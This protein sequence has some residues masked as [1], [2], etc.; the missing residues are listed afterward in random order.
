MSTL[1]RQGDVLFVSVSLPVGLPL[2]SSKQVAVAAGEKAGHRHVLAAAP[3]AEILSDADLEFFRILGGSGLLSHP[4]HD[5]IEL[6]EGDYQ[7]RRQREYAPGDETDEVLADSDA[8]DD[9]RESEDDVTAG[10]VTTLDELRRELGR[11]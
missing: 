11:G 2:K 6:P 10:R 9:L 1:Y 5:A 4:E 3:G 7:V 8:L